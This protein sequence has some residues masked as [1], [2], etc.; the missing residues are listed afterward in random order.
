VSTRAATSLA[1]G[2]RAGRASFTFLASAAAILIAFVVIAANFVAPRR[3]EPPSR[4]NAK[5]H[6][7]APPSASRPPR[8]GV[9]D[10]ARSIRPRSAGLR[11]Q[12]EL[13]DELGQPLTGEFDVEDRPTRPMHPHGGWRTTSVT[14]V[15][16]PRIELPVATHGSIEFT[17][18]H[19]VVRRLGLRGEADA[20]IAT[21]AADAWT[22]VTLHPTTIVRGRIV[23]GEDRPVGGVDVLV[24]GDASGNEPHSRARTDASGAFA[25]DALRTMRNRLFVGDLVYP[26]VAPIDVEASA[27]ELA[28]EPI[29]ID[30]HAATFEV[31]RADGFPAA[32]AGL[33]GVWVGTG[34]G[35]FDTTTDADGRARVTTLLR[36]RWRVNA[37][38]A[39]HGRASRTVELPLAKDEPV[40]ILLP[41]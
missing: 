40:L 21:D 17:R 34:R 31:L 3:P 13:V 36:G 15:R 1:A 39:T 26:C 25:V 32:G 37:S 12:L 33:D 27:A 22:T 28:L 41:R 5:A 14:G 4:A 18:A 8:A 38:D 20:E 19:V 6:E 9:Q 24:R 29:R 16:G 23:D 30:M 10:E 2:A 7:P 11:L 35:R